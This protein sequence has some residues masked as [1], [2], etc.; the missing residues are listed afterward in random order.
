[1]GAKSGFALKLFQ[2]FVRGIQFCCA[3]LILA[4]FSYFLAT[5]ANH[6]LTIH[7][8]VRAV[9]GISGVA[10]VYT[11]LGILL[12]CCLAGRAFFSIIAIILDLAFIVGFIYIAVATRGGASSCTGTVNTVFGKGDA[13][14]DVVDNGNGGVT[15][16]PSFRS[17]CR[18]ETACFAVAIVA[19]FFFVFSAALEL[20]LLRHHRKEKRF[21]PSPANDYTSGYGSKR[22][23]IF[24]WR[25]NRAGTG[26]SQDPNTLPQHSTPAD[27]RDSYATETTRVGDGVTPTNTYNK[28]GEAGYG[29]TGG[30]TQPPVGTHPAAGTHPHGYR[31]EDG[32]YNNA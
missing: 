5:L 9:E 29:H 32:V 15:H 22:R 2:W 24:G 21:G 4:I 27:V 14:T 3:A 31:Y 17:A 8:W 30:V 26:M 16:L 1:M 11:A 19:V 6:D 7:T 28:Y 25:R 18:M 23:G 20:A 10:V 13:N 12:L